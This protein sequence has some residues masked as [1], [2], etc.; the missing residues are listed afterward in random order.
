M[1][2]PELKASERNLISRN[3]GLSKPA[4]TRPK[5]KSSRRGTRLVSPTFNQPQTQMQ[6]SSNNLKQSHNKTPIRLPPPKGPSVIIIRSKRAIKKP[7]I[8]PAT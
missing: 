2:Q 4:N 6:T 3:Q 7:K 5:V 1:V 8:A